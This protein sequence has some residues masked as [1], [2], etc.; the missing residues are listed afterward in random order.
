MSLGKLLPE[1]VDQ[2]KI[3]YE[4]NCLG[5]LV[6]SYRK[7]LESGTMNIDWEEEK[8]SMELIQYM[9][10]A[11]E[12]RGLTIHIVPEPRLYSKEIYDSGLKPKESPRID[13]Q[14]LSFNSSLELV[15]NMEA[16]NLAEI[17]W[18]KSTGAS[19]K[20]SYLTG[21]YIKTGIENFVNNR[22]G[23]GCLVGYVL[24]GEPHKVAD[25]IN[26]LLKTEGRDAEKLYLSTAIEGYNF[27][28]QSQHKRKK[29][30][31]SF[32]LPHI[33]LKFIP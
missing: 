15:Y 28:F 16:K 9:K 25:N 17:D 32:H 30:G 19:V 23:N 1:I 26:A 6:D 5:L 13:L 11:N 8:I 12:E 20:S 22:Y 24:N 10:I 21:R 2:F 33:F 18:K 7:L 27:C 31:L 14:L 29:N 4:K 3:A